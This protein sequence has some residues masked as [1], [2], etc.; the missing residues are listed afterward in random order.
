MEEDCL[1]GQLLKWVR[2]WVLDP[3]HLRLPVQKLQENFPVFKKNSRVF[4]LRGEGNLNQLNPQTY[5]IVFLHFEKKKKKLT[6]S[7]GGVTSVF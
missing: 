4:F 2:R 3:Q 5:C 7:E 1:P 6:F